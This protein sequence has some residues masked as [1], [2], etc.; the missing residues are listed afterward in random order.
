MKVLVGNPEGKRPHR[1]YKP[2][3]KNDIKIDLRET[4]SVCMD[5]INLA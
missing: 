5:W 2:T 4:E 3:L 1:K